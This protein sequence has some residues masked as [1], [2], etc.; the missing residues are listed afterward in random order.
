V[1]P[2]GG[3]ERL[4]AE[5][6][7]K[8]IGC[9][10]PTPHFTGA[11]LSW[12]PDGKWL[13][14]EGLQLISVSTGEKRTLTSSPGEWEADS[15][16]AFSPDGQSVAFLRSR[17]SGVKD[18]YVISSAGGE[19]RRLTSEDRFISGVFWTTDGREIVYSSSATKWA[20]SASLWRVSVSG[21]SPR[22]F[23]AGRENAWDPSISRQGNRLAFTRRAVDVNIWRLEASGAGGFQ[24]P[25]RLIASTQV[26]S[27]PVFSPDG[28][29]IAFSSNRSGTLQ[30]WVCDRDGSHV[31]QLTSFPEPGA[32]LSTWSPDGRYI[33]FSSSG[34]G[35]G[36]IY[37]IAAQGGAPRQL[38]AE[39]STEGA[40]NW[41]R[42]GRWV[43]FAS[44]RTGRLEIWKVPAEGGTAVQ[45][46]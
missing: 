29:R 26:E 9:W 21:G 7:G 40:P 19:P 15:D 38:T 4:V 30:V 13:A 11:R 41:S 5:L 1:S 20:E 8:G 44:N 22:R 27:A 28:K 10:W 32:A 42:N 3:P 36:D 18:L 39:S 31:D 46:T 25:T 6:D 43:Y 24:K 23:A 12:S 2:L 17:R 35:N 33:A 45:V 37:V 16:P 34:R 14:V